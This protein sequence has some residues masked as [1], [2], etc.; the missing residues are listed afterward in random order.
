MF[1]LNISPFI[2]YSQLLC[3]HLY[4]E[5]KLTLKQIN[6]KGVIVY[7]YQKGAVTPHHLNRDTKFYLCLSVQKS[8]VCF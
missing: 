7:F 2:I 1:V 5:V 8:V 3:I 4:N 6:N